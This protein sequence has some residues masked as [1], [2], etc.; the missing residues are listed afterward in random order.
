[1]KKVDSPK[2]WLSAPFV[3]SLLL[4]RFVCLSLLEPPPSQILGRCQVRLAL[5]TASL[6]LHL[7]EML[8]E[9]T[10]TLKTL[11]PKSPKP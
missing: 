2:V 3:S 1:M 8:L 4:L 5:R 10:L 6:L 7:V 9:K 11:N